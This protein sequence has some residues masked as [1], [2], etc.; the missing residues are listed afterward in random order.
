MNRRTPTLRSLGLVA[1]RGTHADLA[2]LAPFHYAPAP[3]AVIDRI[4]AIAPRA[5]GPAV[6]VLVLAMP[7][8][9]DCWRR[10]AFG[11]ALARPRSPAGRARMLGARIRTIARLI[12]DP[13][14]RGVGLGRRL[15]RAALR[16]AG[17]PHVEAVAAM[18]RWCPV[19]SSAGMRR[20]AGALSRRDERLL[21]QCRR[22]G[23]RPHHLLHG[24]VCRRLARDGA[25]VRAARTWIDGSGSLR[26]HKRRRPA[27]LLR[28]VARHFHPWRTIY[29]WSR[30]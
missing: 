15:V 19:F 20:W 6:A 18:G 4:L 29:T 22:R 17:V 30:R 12:V 10:A 9:N 24:P 25:F 27:A 1:R 14:Y 13:R 5:G 21:T 28:I 16:S 7:T 26:G 11:G 3:P 2:A 8:L 23:L